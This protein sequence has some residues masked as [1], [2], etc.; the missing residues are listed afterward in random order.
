MRKPTQ[1]QIDR[2][3]GNVLKA[4]ED[5]CWL[6]QRGV[7]GWGYGWLSIHNIPVRAHQVAWYIA[8]GVWPSGTTILH[9]CDNP[10][11]CNPNHLQQ[12]TQSDNVRDCI[13][14]GRHK[15]PAIRR[16]SKNNKAKLNEQDVLLILD[17]SKNLTPTEIWRR[18]EFRDKVSLDTIW[19]VV[20]RRTW[21]HVQSQ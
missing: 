4:G 3:L 20:N 7:D 14:K 18:P 12:G 10:P 21:R 6:W 8:T 19:K 15:P 13:T 17:C 5:E 16:G 2:F 9:K 11:C 1:K